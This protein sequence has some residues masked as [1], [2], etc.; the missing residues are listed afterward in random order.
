MKPTLKEKLIAL[1]STAGARRG[2]KEI[3]AVLPEIEAAISHGVPRQLI[4]KT[5]V[6]D[7]IEISFQNFAKTLYR[8]RK[9]TQPEPQ[10]AAGTV[11]LPAKAPA[12]RSPRQLKSGK[13]KP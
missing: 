9:K 4:H 5:I 7:G 3:A 12:P 11:N 13:R 8:L 2:S 1:Q 10:P 6:E